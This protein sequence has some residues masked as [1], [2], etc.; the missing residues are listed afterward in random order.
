VHGADG[1]GRRH[2]TSNVEFDD[3]ESIGSAF[4]DDEPT[5][6]ECKNLRRVAD[7]LPWAVW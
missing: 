5:E 7:Q 1:T 3:A 6:E 4:D 2:A